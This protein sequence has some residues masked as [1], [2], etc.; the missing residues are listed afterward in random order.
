LPQRGIFLHLGGLSANLECR[1]GAAV[2][3]DLGVG[4]RMLV[5]DILFSALVK[6]D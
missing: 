3:L 1:A 4:V 6:S 5:F 2:T